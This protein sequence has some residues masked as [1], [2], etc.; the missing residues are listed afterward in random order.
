MTNEQKA[1]EEYRSWANDQ[2]NLDGPEFFTMKLSDKGALVMEAIEGTVQVF[3]DK[4]EEILK[5][6]GV[7]NG[8]T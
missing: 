3:V 2:L 6:N 5:K 7:D 8:T 1:I 4:L